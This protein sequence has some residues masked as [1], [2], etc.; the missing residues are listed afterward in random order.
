M[1]D[2]TL[3]ST[4]FNES[5][6]TFKRDQE[7]NNT[8]W[9]PIFMGIGADQMWPVLFTFQGEPQKMSDSSWAGHPWVGLE[10][11]PLCATNAMDKY[12]HFRCP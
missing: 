1:S 10:Q 12:L 11:G 3:I 5:D 6:K 8:Y 9:R 7:N 4:P 2:K